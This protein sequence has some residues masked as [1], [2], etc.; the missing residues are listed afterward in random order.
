MMHTEAVTSSSAIR[1]D[2]PSDPPDSGVSVAML[3]AVLLRQRRTLYGFVLLGVVTALIVIGVRRSTYTSSFSFVPESGVDASRAGLAGL[4]GQFGISLGALG[5]AAQPPQLY[6]DLLLSREVLAPIIAD[7][8]ATEA[9]EARAPLPVV[10]GVRGTSPALVVEN[11]MR[12]LRRDVISSTVAARTTGMVRVMVRT[13]SARVSVELANR[14]LEELHHF[15][16]VTRQSRAREERIFTEKRLE[17][18]RQALRLAEAAIER[19]QQENRQFQSSPS[20]V[21]QFE[22]LQREIQLH[23]QVVVSLAQQYE[24]NR[25]RE[26]RD[27][28]VITVFER[29]V[30]AARADPGLRAIIL[31]FSVLAALLVGVVV[32]LV[33]D[34]WTREPRFA[35]E[36]G[37]VA[38]RREWESLRG[39][40]SV[41]PGSV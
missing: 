26:V 3:V 28:P 24:E 31:F 37:V 5:S 39:R 17:E 22:R 6:A 11:S 7:S 36:P 30:L 15:N 25:I 23:Q 20:L 14:L 29:P 13:K 2:T 33:R 19:F 10:L 27:T 38:L 1:G 40:H 12:A 9:G 8:F 18:S 32:V 21:L 4:A 41:D 34:L 16:N 35:R